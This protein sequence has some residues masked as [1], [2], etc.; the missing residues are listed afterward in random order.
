MATS[1]ICACDSARRSEMRAGVDGAFAAIRL[2]VAASTSLLAS[3]STAAST[4]KSACESSPISFNLRHMSYASPYK[5]YGS[6]TP[7]AGLQL[8]PPVLVGAVRQLLQA[9]GIDPKAISD[10]GEVDSQALIALA[11]DRIEIRSRLAPPI[12]IDLKTPPDAKT[13]AYLREIQPALV[14]TGKAGRAEVAPYGMPHGITPGLAIAGKQLGWGL[15]AVAL[16]LVF[17]GGAIFRPKR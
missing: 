17:L 1:R 15:G 12:V 7:F 8:V 3:D 9:Q 2:S 4:V 11:F 5:K 16:G 6:S 13:Q 14:M 10:T